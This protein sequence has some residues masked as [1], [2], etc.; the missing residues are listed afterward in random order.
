MALMKTGITPSTFKRLYSGPGMVYI[1][2]G[3]GT[4]RLV[5]TTK[6]G[7]VLSITDEIRQRKFD[8]APGAVKGDKVREGGEFK[9]T[10]NIEEFPTANILMALPGAVSATGATHDVITRS[11]QIADGDYFENVT[12]IVEKS[13]TSQVVYFKLKNCLAKGE[14]NIDAKE[15]DDVATPIEFTAH[16]LSNAL[17]TD[18]FEIGNPLEATTGF[19]TLT[20][21]AGANGQ[22]LGNPSQIIASGDDG[23]PVVAYPDS[24]YE[25]T[26]WSDASPTADRTDTNI[27]ADLT[28][29]ATFSAI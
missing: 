24:G 9:L 28:V 23:S 12:L 7:N 21:L 17:D 11:A 26:A 18:P 6:G 5:G 27:T 4:Q 16:R 22:I 20:Y 1:N 29:T 3:T 13:G 2:Y 25:F 14:F 8:G 19:Y 15:K 10:V